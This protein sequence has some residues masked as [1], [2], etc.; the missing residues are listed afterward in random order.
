VITSFPLSVK[1]EARCNLLALAAK[2]CSALLWSAIPPG[3]GEFTP[4][5]FVAPPP[6]QGITPTQDHA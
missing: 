6:T 1:H 5:P 2:E 4:D 3:E